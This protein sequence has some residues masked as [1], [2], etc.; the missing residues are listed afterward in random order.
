MFDFRL[1]TVD[2]QSFA[3]FYYLDNK[4][5]FKSAE[6]FVLFIIK[7]NCKKIADYNFSICFILEN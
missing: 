5:F 7:R 1:V 3:L 6:K 4:H 2:W